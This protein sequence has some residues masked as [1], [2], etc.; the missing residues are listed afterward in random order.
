MA[1]KQKKTEAELVDLI[2]TEIRKRPEC[3]HI[4]SVA[5]T[6]PPQQASHHPNWDA[7]FTINGNEIPPERAF[8][9]VRELRAQFDLV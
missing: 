7:A 8:M 3:N 1:T 2:M 9:I 4:M 6:R 5:I